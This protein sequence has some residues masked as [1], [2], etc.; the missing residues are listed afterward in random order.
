MKHCVV[1]IARELYKMGKQVNR[2]NF[3]EFLPFVEAMFN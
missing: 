3:G 1:A 2:V